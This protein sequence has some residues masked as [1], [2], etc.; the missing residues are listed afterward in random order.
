MPRKVA[1]LSTKIR[2]DV[3][4]FVHTMR[5]E[6]TR[7][8]GGFKRLA[9]LVSYIQT[10]VDAPTLT[11][12]NLQTILDDMGL[13]IPFKVTRTKSEH[14]PKSHRIRWLLPQ[15][16]ALAEDVAR[17]CK[18][19]GVNSPGADRIAATNSDMR[20][21]LR[22]LQSHDSEDPTEPAPTPP[23]ANGIPVKR[24]PNPATIPVANSPALF[25]ER[26]ATP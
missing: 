21:L 3:S 23:P 18:G 20:K 14:G 17:V 26:V 6:L 16:I 25:Q 9:D 7:N 11:V 22:F 24:V 4:I 2:T 1:R 19:L 10:K 5:D 13:K 12:S 8:E 15:I